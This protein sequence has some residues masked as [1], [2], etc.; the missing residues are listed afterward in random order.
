MMTE[1]SSHKEEVG[2]PMQNNPPTGRVTVTA[3]DIGSRNHIFPNNTSTDLNIAL[4]DEIIQGIINLSS[5]NRET[6]LLEAEKFRNQSRLYANPPIAYNLMLFRYYSE[7]ANEIKD[8]TK[9]QQLDKLSLIGELPSYVYE[10]NG[11][12]LAGWSAMKTA[13]FWVRFSVAMF[14]FIS[15]V[16]MSSVP[17]ISHA[18]FNPAEDFT[19]SYIIYHFVFGHF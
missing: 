16:I 8:N 4:S 11:D 1:L 10:A 14:A 9:L 15:L 2:N 18:D 7:I 19:V 5:L 13:V 17:Y 3:S 6:V 12:S